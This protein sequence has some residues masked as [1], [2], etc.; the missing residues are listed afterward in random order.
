MNF[1][2]VDVVGVS[3]SSLF[4]VICGFCVF[5]LV[6]THLDLGLVNNRFL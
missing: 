2:Y 5:L 1:C 3:F 6:W 4:S